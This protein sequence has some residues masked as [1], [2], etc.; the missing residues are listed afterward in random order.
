MLKGESSQPC[1]AKMGPNRNGS[2]KTGT[3]TAAATASIVVSA[4]SDAKMDAAAV[5]V[6]GTADALDENA[7]PV[8]LT[9]TATVMEEIYSPGGGRASARAR[10]VTGRPHPLRLRYRAH[11]RACPTE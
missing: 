10:S 2:Q 9:K 4:A 7:K 3:P 1:S 6:I 8:K 5:K 11:S